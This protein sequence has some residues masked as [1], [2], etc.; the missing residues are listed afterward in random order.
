MP[1]FLHAF[2]VSQFGEE[3]MRHP[4]FGPVL[5]VVASVVDGCGMMLMAIT[6]MQAVQVPPDPPGGMVI[7]PTGPSPF[8]SIFTSGGLITWIIVGGGS[9]WAI[10]QVGELVYTIIFKVRSGWLTAA[11]GTDHQRANDCEQQRALVEKTLENCRNEVMAAIA[12]NRSKDDQIERLAEQME[13]KD[14][15]IK[16]KDEQ[17]QRQNLEFLKLSLSVSHNNTKLIDAAAAPR[18]SSDAIPVLIAPSS[19]PIPVRNVGEPI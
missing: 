13:K 16:E 7:P 14:G 12:L 2:M 10:R 19:E 4:I 17:I 8:P 15:W 1:G 9:V 18:S 5:N 11:A 6:G 3:T